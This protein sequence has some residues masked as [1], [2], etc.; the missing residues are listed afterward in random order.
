MELEED[1][2]EKV[3]QSWA[4]ML[5]PH[6]LNDGEWHSFLFGKEISELGCF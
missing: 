2:Q 1:V 5:C 6:L 4:A 3:H